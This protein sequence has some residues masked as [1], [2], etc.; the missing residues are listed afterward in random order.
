MELKPWLLFAILAGLCWGTYV[1]F[2]QQGIRGL[3][4][5]YGSFLCVGLAYFLI[6]VLV[7]I[8]A[9]GSNA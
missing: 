1:P 2:V 7:P 8:I 3:A 9:Y 4:S 6:A 5:P